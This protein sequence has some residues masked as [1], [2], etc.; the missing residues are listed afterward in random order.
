MNIVV[1]NGC[2]GS[3][4]DTFENFVIETAKEDNKKVYKTSI[5]NY[6]KHCA[7]LLGWEGG[8]TDKDRK[9]LSDLKIALTEWND[10]PRRSIEEDIKICQKDSVDLLFID[11]REIEDIEWLKS[12]YS[13]I[14]LLVDREINREYG[15]IAD[16][17]VMDIVYDIVI[18]NTGTLEDLKASAEVFWKEII[19]SEN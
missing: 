15:N 6:V 17:G 7:G 18:K 16:D 11:M 10:S 5:I 8:K 4:K 3:G 14:S 9:F 13:I 19:N 1:V 2:G 12:K